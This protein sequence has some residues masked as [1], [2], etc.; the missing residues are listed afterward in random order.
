MIIKTNKMNNSHNT[1]CIIPARAGSKGL[2]KKNILKINGE[3]L[4]ARPIKHA[5]RSSLIDEVVVSTDS[6]EIAKIAKSYGAL[7]PFLRPKKLSGDLSTTEE[8]LKYTLLRYEKLT[9]KK[10]D[11][12]VFLTA[13][14]IFRKEEWIDE[15][16]KKLILKK[17]KD[18]ESVFVGYK[19]HKNF[20]EKNKNGKWVRA[21][22]WMAQYASRQIRQYI[23]REDT[24]LCCASRSELWRKGRR[25]GDKVIIIEHKE[26]LSFIDIH[27]SNDLKLANLIFKKLK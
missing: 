9:K 3:P 18:I 19:T 23:V 24:G 11:V 16:I 12:C 5:L 10:Y 1:I 17:N 15:C 6:V 4:I 8:A 26:D 20:W 27:S 7:V 2:K 21:K 25:I 13:T 22:K 14:D